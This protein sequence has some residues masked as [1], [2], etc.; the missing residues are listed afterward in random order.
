[1]GEEMCGMWLG[2]IL[3]FNEG[4][5]KSGA[6]IDV[7][8]VSWMER[9]GYMIGNTI[10]SIWKKWEGKESEFKIESGG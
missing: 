2:C 5:E 3:N 8:T 9:V 6:E 7:K 1:M 4:I 10:A